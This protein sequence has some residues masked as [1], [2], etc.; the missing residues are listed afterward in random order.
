MSKVAAALRSPLRSLSSRLGIVFMFLTIVIFIVSLGILFYQSRHI[1]RN[2]AVG[3]A[4]SV[5]NA[6]MQRLN[7]HIYTIE[8]AT[9]ANSWLVEKYLLPDSLLSISH[10]LVRINPHIDG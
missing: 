3:R 1:I 8:T 7:R 5:L 4:S 9:K 10:R 2:E 6:T